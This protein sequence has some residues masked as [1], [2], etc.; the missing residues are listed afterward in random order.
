MAATNDTNHE[1]KELTD[2]I[3]SNARKLRALLD[4]TYGA[5]TGEN[6]RRMHADRQDEYMWACADMAVEIVEALDRLTDLE[7][8]GKAVAA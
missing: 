1:R 8:D 5:E 2:R 4:N 7:L 6:F 3:Q